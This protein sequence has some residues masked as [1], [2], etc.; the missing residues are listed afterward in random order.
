MYKK[1]IC[2]FIFIFAIL[3]SYPLFIKSA[4]AT[5]A[6]IEPESNI[7]R[8]YDVKS[9]Y[10]SQVDDKTKIDLP[11]AS[12]LN[13]YTLVSH[14]D[15]L[16]L[17]VDTRGNKLN[18]AVKMDNGYIF[19]SDPKYYGYNISAYLTTNG[20][21]EISSTL[22]V[23]GQYSS[24]IEKNQKPIVTYDFDSVVNGFKARI[25][26][27][28]LGIIIN[29]YVSIENGKLKVSVPDNE[30]EENG[31]LKITKSIKLGPDG[32]PARDEN[33][34]TIIE[35]KETLYNFALSAIS[36]FQYFGCVGYDT[37]FENRINGYDFIPD[38]SGAL[39]RFQYDRTYTTRLQKR[40]YGDDMGIKTYTSSVA[41]LSDDI[42]ISLPIYGVVHGYNQ[43]AFLNTITSSA[44][45]AEL[46]HEPFGYSS[47]T[48]QTTYFKFY[49]REQYSIALSTSEQGSTTTLP[50]NRY[51][52]DIKF[53]YS[54][55][56]GDSANYSGLASLYRSDYLNLTGSVEE[57]Y[58]PLGLNVLAQDYKKGLFGKKFIKM[59][60][61]KELS[62]IIQILEKEGVDNFS[63]NY[64]GWNKG[65]YYNNNNYKPKRSLN[66]GTTRS[67]KMTI[68]YMHYKGYNV[69]SNID[70]LTSYTDTKKGV[71]K[72]TNLD[73]FSKYSDSSL[74]DNAYLLSPVGV[75][76]NIL[77]YNKQYE[78]Y[79]FD[80][81]NLGYYSL[82]NFQYRYK[83]T[84]YSRE[85]A[86]YQAVEELKKISESYQISLTGANSYTFDYLTRFY[87]MESNATSY[88][89]L[90]DS[91]PFISLILSG[92]TELF[93]K[94]I[95]FLSDY[96]QLALRLVEYNIYPYFVITNEDSSKLRYTNS[97]F[98]Y[99]TMFSLW[100]DD[101]VEFYSFI[102]KA[103]NN[104]I[105]A[106]M[107][108]HE[109]IKDGVTRVT[110]SNGVK[111][112]INFN[113]TNVS[114]DGLNISSLSYEVVR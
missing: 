36:L 20:L 78:K 113:K 11:D 60:T 82:N 79:K 100:K 103:L 91:V 93:S 108:N 32:R 67:L 37:G 56:E 90:T 2:A 94:E 55:I 14:A 16:T 8:T 87:N 47:R 31:Y 70:L 63:I 104:T 26:F 101:I 84:N 21:S 76:N 54:F 7:E 23:N 85:V 43:Y 15:G 34:N 52:D 72:K 86:I 9:N 74:F 81:I 46:V 24:S 27:D 25:D 88:T 106:N 19:Y 29:I 61:Y 96:D 1:I 73:I 6:D 50:L 40:I 44:G 112:Y 114:V 75:S 77:K 41:H 28:K 68:G 10:Y 95:N 64:T 51:G 107:V 83:G 89:Y 22:L 18:I 99:T 65:G 105:G 45:S 4:S 33:N 69:E 97:E 109:T 53:E 48:I 59:T 38:G 62:Q 111:I 12:V 58:T 39:S 57:D 92:Y 71:V 102:S 110:Y 30:I 35:E 13:G 42:R 49:T 5:Q 17:Y 98:L 66:L 3:M 80:S